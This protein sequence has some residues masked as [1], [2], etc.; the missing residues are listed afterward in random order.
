MSE[1]QQVLTTTFV[2]GLFAAGMRYEA[3]P[4]TNRFSVGRLSAAR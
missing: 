2:I 3:K 1:L 4:C